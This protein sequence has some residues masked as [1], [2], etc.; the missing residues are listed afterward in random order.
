M[1]KMDSNSKAGCLLHSRT[2]I[3]YCKFRSNWRLV[4]VAGLIGFSFP[5]IGQPRNS[6]TTIAGQYLTPVTKDKI[7]QILDVKN[8]AEYTV[9]PLNDQRIKNFNI[10]FSLSKDQF[11]VTVNST[12]KPNILTE[13]QRCE[14]ALKGN[15]SKVQKKL[16]LNKLICLVAE[17][18]NPVNVGP[19][20]CKQGKDV[21][22]NF[23]GKTIPLSEIFSSRILIDQYDIV[24][25]GFLDSDTSESVNIEIFR[26]KKIAD[27]LY[28]S[29][30]YNEE[31]PSLIK[32]D[33]GKLSLPMYSL[34]LDVSKYYAG[35][36]LAVLLNIIF[37]PKN[38]PYVEPDYSGISPDT[39]K[40]K[41][42]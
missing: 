33:S 5:S 1:V 7:Q 16:M 32:E 28:D 23:E 20:Y 40:A 19:A 25:S 42:R 38:L 14:Q 11:N 3:R 31:L 8:F 15:L 17:C 12:P 6:L 26:E 13:L 37:D 29:Y 21:S 18:H 34:I 35:C 39:I 41:Q 22:V 27:W 24:K 2:K 30:R 4:L 10:P 9:T 36:H